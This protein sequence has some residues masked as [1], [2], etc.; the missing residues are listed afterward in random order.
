MPTGVGFT[1]GTLRFN[2]T[3]TIAG[4]YFFELTGT[5]VAGSSDTAEVTGVVCVPMGASPLGAGS[6]AAGF[7]FDAVKGSKVSLGFKTSA[8]HPKRLL[9]PVLLGTD[10]ATELKARAKSG[11][12]RASVSKFLVPETGRYFCV[13][14]STGQGAKAQ[15]S[16]VSA[17]AKIAAGTRGSGKGPKDPFSAGQKFTVDFGALA[18]AKLT[19]RANPD[20]SGLELTALYLYDPAG[21]VVPLAAGDV[22]YSGGAF[23][24]TKTL[25]LSGTW[26]IYIG[27]KSGAQGHFKY[28]YEINQ[29]SGVVYS[30][31]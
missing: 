19:F 28:S 25:G 10:G 17:T 16:E 5:D 14:G 31:D 23:T 12:G 22:S 1:P 21:N 24:V 26:R 6:S 9:R 8:G 20:R 2:G 4:S 30:A 11:N 18:G 3:P 13:T 29:P 27:A 7:Y 15:A